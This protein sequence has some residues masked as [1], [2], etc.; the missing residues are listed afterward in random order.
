MRGKMCN[1]ILYKDVLVEMR[2]NYELDTDTEQLIDKELKNNC[3]CT[4]LLRILFDV[5][6]D[7]GFDIDFEERIES[8]INFHLH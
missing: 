7:Y 8:A 5:R 2:D 6:R 1:C 4:K 3:N